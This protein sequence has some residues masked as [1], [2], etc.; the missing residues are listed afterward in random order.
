MAILAPSQAAFAAD[1]PA[2]TTENIAYLDAQ[3]RQEDADPKLREAEA[4]LEKAKQDRQAVDS[5][6]YLA[7]SVYGNINDSG[8]QKYAGPVR[9][10]YQTLQDA[11][12]K[13]DGVAT[14]DAAVAMANAADD[15]IAKADSDGL[16]RDG[17]KEFLGKGNRLLRTSSEHARKAATGAD[18]EARQTDLDAAKANKVEAGK[19]VRPARDAYRDCLDKAKG[20]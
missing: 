3:D 4:A 19:G 20:Q 5:T 6:R 2:C 11:A 14:A 7:E 9:E 10:A 18:V 12:A 13:Y 16:L 17:D 15:A 1:A 8:T